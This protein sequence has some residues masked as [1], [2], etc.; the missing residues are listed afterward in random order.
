MNRL[1]ELDADEALGNPNAGIPRRQVTRAPEP[2]KVSAKRA[3]DYPLAYWI[4][5]GMWRP[6]TIDAIAK[7]RHKPVSEIEEA[8]RNLEREGKVRAL[9]GG[10]WER[11][12]SA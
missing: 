11:V 1:D 4:Y 7:I 5:A 12:R 8:I 3:P 9:E 10:M 2:R 6:T